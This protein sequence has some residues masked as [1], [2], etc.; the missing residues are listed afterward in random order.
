MP[1]PIPLPK[2]EKQQSRWPM[3]GVE[4]AYG[5]CTTV[6]TFIGGIFI[7]III[8]VDGVTGDEILIPG[9]W[10]EILTH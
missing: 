4:P 10:D 5:S 2:D 8:I 6:V 7:T 9:M 1:I 3:G